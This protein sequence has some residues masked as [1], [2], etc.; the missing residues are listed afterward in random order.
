M[1]TQAQLIAEHRLELD[2][3]FSRKYPKG[4]FILEF[5]KGLYTIFWAKTRAT[6]RTSPKGIGVHVRTNVLDVIDYYSKFMGSRVIH[7]KTEEDVIKTAKQKQ[8]PEYM[9]AIF[10]KELKQ[11]NFKN[12]QKDDLL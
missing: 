3:E 2:K 12:L 1:K 5:Q 9:I 11:Y 7:F 8:F 6:S 10:Q 4:D